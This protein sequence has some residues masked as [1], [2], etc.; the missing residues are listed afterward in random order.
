[1]SDLILYQTPDGRTR[2]DIRASEKRFYQKVH[3]F[4]PRVIPVAMDA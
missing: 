1:M 2:I 4:C 3:A